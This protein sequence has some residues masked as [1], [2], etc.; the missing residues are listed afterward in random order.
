MAPAETL[1]TTAHSFPVLA[2]M[3]L[4]PLGAA[5]ALLGVPLLLPASR[6]TSTSL[7]IVRSE[8]LGIALALTTAM[9]SWPW[10]AT[11]SCA[12]TTG[13]RPSSSPSAGPCP[14]P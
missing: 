1:I 6:G 9:A 7:G 13:A 14:R 8:A 10:R 12:W 3:Q 2:L 4:L 11:S 5:L